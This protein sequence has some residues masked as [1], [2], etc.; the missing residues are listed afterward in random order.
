MS[1]IE[2]ESPGLSV[3]E[4]LYLFII[5]GPGGRGGPSEEFRHAPCLSLIRFWSCS[6]R[7]CPPGGNAS[8]LQQSAQ[9]GHP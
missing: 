9:V 5:A 3:T 1:V 8:D 2:A 6:Q 7:F 4:S